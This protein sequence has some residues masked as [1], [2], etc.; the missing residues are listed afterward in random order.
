MEGNY[1]VVFDIAQAGYQQWTFPAF[2]LIFVGISSLLLVSRSWRFKA[3]RNGRSERAAKWGILMMT[4]FAVFWTLAAF[5]G[6]YSEYRQLRRAAETGKYESVEGIVTNFVPM[7]HEG[8]RDEKF[9][10]KNTCFSY[11]DYSGRAGFNHTSSHGGPIKEG[12]P[13]RIHHI[14]G[15]IIQLE[16][17]RQDSR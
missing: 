13:V 7:P 2:G 9:C 10:V 16:V 5:L 4:G 8:H 17:A 11:S 15:V 1:E 6:T 14:N 12:L 3:F